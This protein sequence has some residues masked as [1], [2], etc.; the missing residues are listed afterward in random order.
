MVRAEKGLKQDG[1]SKAVAV[2][3][4]ARDVSG[5]RD[6]HCL[7]GKDCTRGRDRC[8]E[9][10]GGDGIESGGAQWRGNTACTD[11]NG[12]PSGGADISVDISGHDSPDDIVA[13]GTRPDTRQSVLVLDD[14]TEPEEWSLT[15]SRQGRHAAPEKTGAGCTGASRV[16]PPAQKARSSA[17]CPSLSREVPRSYNWEGEEE[18]LQVT[19]RK[20]DTSTTTS[21]RVGG[22]PHP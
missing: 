3:A 15:A 18:D 14:T 10:I 1:A 21:S 8:D 5:A 22:E 7:C 16:V 13:S 6:V 12:G 19:W 4:A 11:P 17:A 20:L 9:M 2:T